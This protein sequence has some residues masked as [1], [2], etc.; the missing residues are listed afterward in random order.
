MF[1]ID[2]LWYKQGEFDK[3]QELFNFMFISLILVG[4]IFDSAVIPY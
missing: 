3:Y 4:L 2:F 1:F